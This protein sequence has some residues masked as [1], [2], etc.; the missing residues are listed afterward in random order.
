MNDALDRHDKM[1]RLDRSVVSSYHTQDGFGAVAV[2]I[3]AVIALT[4]G[5]IIFVTTK[6]CEKESQP[7]TAIT[8]L[9]KEINK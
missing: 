9:S 6:S 8:S 5:L 1:M 4:L 3:L 7:A 2:V